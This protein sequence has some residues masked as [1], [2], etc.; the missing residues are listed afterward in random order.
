M[1]PPHAGRNE[2]H[3]L[4]SFLDSCVGAHG[5]ARVCE[6]QFNAAGTSPAVRLAKSVMILKRGWLE[7]STAHAL[8]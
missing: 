8:R 3:N 2:T 6:A 5:F 1:C 7:T 4:S